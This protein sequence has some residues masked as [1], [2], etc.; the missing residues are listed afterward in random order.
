L[1]NDVK[2]GDSQRPLREAVADDI[3]AQIIH[4]EVAPGVRLLEEDIAASLGVSRNP[5][6]EALQA[7]AVEGFVEIVP[8]RGAHVAIVDARRAVELFEVR[9]PLEG[10]VAELAAHRRN[11]ADVDELR[12]ILVEARARITDG[13]L[14]RLPDLNTRFHDGLC[15]AAGNDLLTA[16]LHRLSH[17]VQWVYATRIRERSHDSW[18]EHNA[19]VDAIERSDPTLARRVSEGHVRAAREAFIGIEQE[20]SAG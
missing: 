15:R 5:V 14:E 6:R 9:L 4:G 17:L 10:L 13:H 1:E 3:R 12:A 20:R 18:N 19:L 8:R 16:T 7:L 11:A 2:L